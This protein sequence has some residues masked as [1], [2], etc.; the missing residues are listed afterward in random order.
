[1]DAREVTALGY[2]YPGLEKWKYTKPDGS[3]DQKRHIDFLNHK[4][5]V[6][7][8]S[9]WAAAEKAEL[10]AD[11]NQPDGVGLMSLSSLQNVIKKDPIDLIG[12]DDYVV[13][14]IYEKYCSNINLLSGL[15]NPNRFALNGIKFTIHIFIGKV[16]DELPYSFQEPGSQVG[17]VVNFSTEPGSMGNSSDG[18]PNCRAQQEDHTE[19][20]GRVI[21]TNAL[22]TRWKNQ[23][24]HEPEGDGPQTLASMNPAD[25]VKF[26]TYNL[27]WRVTSM[28]T[29][30]EVDRIPS[31]KVSVA[32]GKANHYADR[33]K[34]SRFYD[35]KGAHE[36]TQG[37]PGGA[38][39]EDGLYPPGY[40]YSTG[41]EAPSEI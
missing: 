19:S 27:H 39:P 38:G 17:V 4:L 37:R 35:Y 36:V 41:T 40:E 23:V 2:T 28:G 11:P 16:P 21:L 9:A 3:Y 33:T 20:T 15:A 25:V 31:L 32:V 34:P 18:C 22:I 13:N 5:N 7:Y 29:S 6:D 24:Q 30:V 8:N 12:V 1:M 14:V 26:L 10:T